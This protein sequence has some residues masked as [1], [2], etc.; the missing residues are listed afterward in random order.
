MPLFCH[1]VF[2]FYFNLIHDCKYIEKYFLL[3][4]QLYSYHSKNRCILIHKINDQCNTILL[5]SFFL[6]ITKTS[7]ELLKL[8]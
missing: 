5:I 2:L 8:H 4:E 6:G 7:L 3:L 1:T